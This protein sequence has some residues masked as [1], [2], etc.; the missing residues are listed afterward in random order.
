M[1]D[2]QNWTGYGVTPQISF[3]RRKS[4]RI[5]WEMTFSLHIPMSGEQRTE[6]GYEYLLTRDGPIPT[7]L[8]FTVCGGF[9]L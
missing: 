8:I 7:P 1:D 9:R 3:L 5:A 2:E 6:S 4:H